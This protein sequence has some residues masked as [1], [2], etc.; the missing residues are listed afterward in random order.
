MVKLG[1]NTPDD[2]ELMFSTG[3]SRWEWLKKNGFEDFV[4]LIATT[5]HD[6]KLPEQPK[7]YKAVQSL[8]ENKTGK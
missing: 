4:R 2:A 1:A 5:F 3:R 7:C 8:P 6:G